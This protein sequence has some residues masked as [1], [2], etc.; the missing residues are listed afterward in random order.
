MPYD[1]DSFL[2]GIAVG[3]NMQSWPEMHGLGK[4]FFAFTIFTTASAL[5]F[6]VYIYSF[7]GT[8]YWGD[9]TSEAATTN[10]LRPYLTHTYANVG[11]YQI[12]LIGNIYNLR[13]NA[14]YSARLLTVDS[15]FPRPVYA[16]GHSAT[17]ISL[18]EVFDGCSNL[19]N[20]PKALFQNFRGVEITGLNN[21]FRNCISLPAFP[22]RLFDGLTF[23][24]NGSLAAEGMFR[25][26]RAVREF[27]TD[28]FS[29]PGFELVVSVRNLFS[30]CYALKKMPVD[31]LPFKSAALFDE[32]CRY[33]HSLEE[34]PEGMLEYCTNGT[35]FDYAFSACLM[36][37]DIPDDLF[38]YCPDLLT[39]EYCFWSTPIT[40]I[41]VGLLSGKAGLL[42]VNGLFRNTD[43]RDI[44]GDLF[45]GCVAL[46]SVVQTFLGCSELT[47][48]PGGLFDGC[49]ELIN[50]RGTFSSC[51]NI[52]TV[53]AALF[54]HNPNMNRFTDCFSG[55][56]GITSAVPELWTM[57]PDAQY[58]DSCFQG[59][60]NAA[61]YADIPAGWGGPG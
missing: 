43:I 14:G 27:P 46:T 31:K 29:N 25:G 10:Y 37:A 41:P 53:G 5:T 20:I 36:L 55:C 61:N 28:I 59:C 52:G 42:S 58:Y 17:S 60:V 18:T 57:F 12:K 7:S 15:P 3:R 56:S 38:D 40:S 22:N 23:S 33:C 4:D 32:F 16:D 6:G 13:F 35:S 49:P 19:I 24:E 11:V 44:P 45:D 8:V 30:G 21:L 54:R 48:V 34:L 26:C 9:G 51:P 1:R 2:A 47:E 39:A 50:A